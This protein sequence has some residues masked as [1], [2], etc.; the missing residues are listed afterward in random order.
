MRFEKTS[1]TFLASSC[2]NS[3]HSFSRSERDDNRRERREKTSST[4]VAIASSPK[5]TRLPVKTAPQRVTHSFSLISRLKNLQKFNQRHSTMMESDFE[6]QPAA[7]SS[8]AF[9]PESETTAR[10][11]ATNMTVHDTYMARSYCP[12]PTILV[13]SHIFSAPSRSR[14]SLLPSQ[15]VRRGRDRVHLLLQRRSGLSG[16][17]SR[18]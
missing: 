10:E 2:Q 4:F 18:R 16:I 11:I 8:F 17:R 6:S 5:C 15:P 14:T 9:L 13:S 7:R 12:L 1:L 3:N